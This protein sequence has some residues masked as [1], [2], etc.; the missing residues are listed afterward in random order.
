MAPDTRHDLYT[1]VGVLAIHLPVDAL[2]RLATAVEALR[3][4]ERESVRDTA[5]GA[6]PQLQVR[7]HL[8]VALNAWE[9][10]ADRRSVGQLA[11][12]F[13]GAAA[14]RR[15][16]ADK[17]TIELIWTG[18]EAPAIPLRRTDQALLDL[19]ENAGQRLL[20][21]SFAVYTVPAIVTALQ[22]ATER[23]VATTLC[24]ETTEDSEGRFHGDP[25]GLEA[26]R[27]WA[28]LYHWPADQRGR[29]ER[30]TVGVL[31]AKA[32][33]AD[34]QWLYL[35]SA[36]LTR[37]ALSINMELGV[38]IRG[39]TAPAKVEQQC[40]SLIQRGVLRPLN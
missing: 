39:G 38:L 35:S 11:A 3:E 20:I 31:H 5:L 37:Y 36:N 9:A 10:Q 18:P 12:L 4:D 7:A 6:L 33:V 15:V 8:E 40:T 28:T 1:A 29:S 30:G 32:A 22:R 16:S 21:I 24:V 26:L 34:G 14:V 25:A 27:P 23:G 17:E 2:D 13:R 19:I